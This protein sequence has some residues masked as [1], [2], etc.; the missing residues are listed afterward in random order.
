MLLSFR[1]PDGGQWSRTVHL[2]SLRRS[3][4][5]YETQVSSRYEP[6]SDTSAPDHDGEICGDV[7]DTHD[8]DDDDAV[9]VEN[10][11]CYACIE[12]AQ[13][14]NIAATVRTMTV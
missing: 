5:G 4:F 12:A 2:C 11:D 1:L 14:E 8:R 10:Y 6:N 9:A 7:D 3:H 13:A